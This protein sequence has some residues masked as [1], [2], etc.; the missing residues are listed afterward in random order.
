VRETERSAQRESLSLLR[1]VAA[2]KMA[3]SDKTRKAAAATIEAV[4]AGVP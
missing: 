4:T 2:G 3:V 1:L